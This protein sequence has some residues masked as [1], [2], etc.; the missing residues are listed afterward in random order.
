MQ[1][2]LASFG[3]VEGWVFE[4][5]GEASD[6]IHSLIHNMVESRFRVVGQQA[7]GPGR[8]RA[9]PDLRS[10]LVGSLRRQ[11]SFLAVRANAM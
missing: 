7:G 2:Q 6:T 9:L 8:A 4:V 5:W 1:W 11:V 10:L 3:N